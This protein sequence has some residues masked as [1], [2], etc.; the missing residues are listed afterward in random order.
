MKS[1]KRIIIPA[2]FIVAILALIAVFVFLPRTKSGERPSSPALTVTTQVGTQPPTLQAGVVTTDDWLNL[3]AQTPIPH[4]TPLPDYKWTP[5]DGTYAK[6][7]PSLPQWWACRRCADYR[8]AGGIWKLQ[9]DK[10]VMRIYYPIT[11]WRSVASSTVSG[12]RL[13]IFN[14]PYCPQEVGEYSWKLGDM[15]NL[16]DRSLEIE[17]IADPCS[18]ELRGENLS[19]QPWLSCMPP[20][21]MTG[22]SDHWH[23]PP[24]CEENPVPPVS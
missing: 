15:W 7:D 8:P 1:K 18:I 13:Y 17:V 4:T 19:N 5:I 24:G 6:L 23:K 3:Q 22:A 2:L 10:G 11:G 16:A 21:E 14:D 9:F 12:D 20:N